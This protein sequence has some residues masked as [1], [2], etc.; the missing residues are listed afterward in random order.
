MMREEPR[1]LKRGLKDI[2]PLFQTSLPQERLS[3]TA[4]SVSGMPLQFLSVLCP[5]APADSLFFNACLA[6]KMQSMA[7]E[8]AMISVADKNLKP[9][10]PFSLHADYSPIK[11]FQLSLHQFDQVS[12]SKSR[13]AENFGSSV[14]FFDFNYENPICLE[15]VLPILD[16]WIFLIKPSQESMMEGYKFIKA[17]LPLNSNLE[18]FMIAH[19]VESE[20]ASSRFYEKFSDMVSRRLGITLHWLGNFDSRYPSSMQNLTIESLQGTS[21]SD[22]LEKRAFAG[23]V[24]PSRQAI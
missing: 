16:K 2:S 4:S 23:F 24:H 21:L 19:G 13:S 12:H 3:V 5:E 1:H 15:R 10:T 20:K 18:Y 8:C 11:R 17:S 7:Y 9:K 22:S 14:I 6:S